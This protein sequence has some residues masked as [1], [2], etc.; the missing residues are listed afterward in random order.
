MPGKIYFPMI[1][2]QT[3]R[4][5]AN[6]K[7]LLFTPFPNCSGCRLASPILS[8]MS[9]EEA[10]WHAAGWQEACWGSDIEIAA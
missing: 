4:G 8:Y 2:W 6:A 1:V 5:E 9:R 7:Y 10:W 3:F